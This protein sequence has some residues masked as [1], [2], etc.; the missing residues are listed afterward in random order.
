MFVFCCK[1][2]TCLSFPNLNNRFKHLMSFQN[3]NNRFPLSNH[4]Q[5]KFPNIFHIN[6]FNIFN[7]YK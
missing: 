3:L 6:I 7:I 4:N 5:D 2:K 1:K